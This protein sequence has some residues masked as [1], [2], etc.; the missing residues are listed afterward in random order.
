MPG[1]SVSLSAKR[2]VLAFA[3]R[4]R[5]LREAFEAPAAV[6]S[7]APSVPAPP[8][9]KRAGRTLLLVGAGLAAL[10]AGGYYGHDYWTVG[11]FEVS[12][13]DAYVQA[14]S[15]T[16][17]PKVS[18]Y[19]GTVLVADN[20]PVKTGQVLARIDDRDFAVALQQARA[21]VDAAR[22]AVNGKQAQLEAQQSVIDVG[23]SHRQCRPGQC[24]LRRT[25]RP[26]LCDPG[27]VR[28]WQPA[29]RAAGGVPHRRGACRDRP[30]YGGT[31]HR[32]QAGRP[33]ERRAGAGAGDAGA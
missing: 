21:D 15:T 3:G 12:T 26:A 4:T 2:P 31:H 8:A 23:Q 27:H 5:R 24:R 18:G 10:A 13:D 28:L 30:G 17:A 29:E 22:A 7:L 9:R 11:R 25:G 19:I 32:A 14:D 33:A 20:E 1:H 16:V 6:P